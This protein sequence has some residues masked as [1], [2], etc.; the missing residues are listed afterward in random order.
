MRAKEEKL[1]KDLHYEM[2]LF[3]VEGSV[4]V[5]NVLCHCDW[6]ELHKKE[7]ESKHKRGSFFLQ[8]QFNWNTLFS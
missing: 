8:E 2:E 6:K 1:E 4:V 3:A 7:L 5:E